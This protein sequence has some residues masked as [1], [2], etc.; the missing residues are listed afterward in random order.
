MGAWLSEKA[1]AVWREIRAFFRW[2][3]HG[4][5]GRKTPW[6]RRILSVLFFLA[7]PAPVLLLLIF[8]FLPIP[9]TPQMAV[10]L[11]TF[12]PVSYHWREADEISPYLARAVIGSEDQNFCVHHGFDFKAID[13]AWRDYKVRHKPLRGASTISQQAARELFLTNWRSFI[14]KGIEAYLTVLLEALWPK[15]RIMTAYLNIVDWGNGNFGAEAASEMYFGI[16]AADLNPTQA[17][18]LAA[19]LPNP[20]KWK[21]ARPGRYVRH[22]TGTLIARQHQVTAAGIDW[23]IQ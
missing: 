1:A 4:Q 16:A 21:A 17:A 11:I 10:N 6:V 5:A 19:I 14:R 7:L 23:C 12:S 13:K 18:R 22:R 15:K 9:F 3:W 8:R 20:T 2:L